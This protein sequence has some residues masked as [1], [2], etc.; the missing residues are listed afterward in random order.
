[1]Q[2]RCP[3]PESLFREPRPEIL[4][5]RGLAVAVRAHEGGAESEGGQALQELLPGDAREPVAD[6]VDPPDG[7]RVI[8]GPQ[9]RLRS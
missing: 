7:E 4:Q 6:G 9:R 2:G 3:Y 8:P 1:M 5:Q